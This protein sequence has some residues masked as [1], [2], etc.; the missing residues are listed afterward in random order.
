MNYRRFMYL[1]EFVAVGSLDA[2]GAERLCWE[3]AKYSSRIFLVVNGRRVM[4][5]NLPLC[6]DA[7][8]ITRGTTVAVEV[9][10]TR[11]TSDVEQ[12]QAIAGFVDAFTAILAEWAEKNPAPQPRN[13]AWLSGLRKFRRAHGRRGAE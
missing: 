3:C 4:A 8:R 2:D 7:L 1:D 10:G 6:W 9:T 12:Q 5:Q 13:R 11:Q